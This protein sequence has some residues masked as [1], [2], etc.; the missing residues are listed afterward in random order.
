[1]SNQHA[2]SGPAA[3]VAPEPSLAERARTLAILGRIGTL[4]THSRKF[5]G[6][7]FGSLMPYAADETGRPVLFISSMAMHTQNLQQDSRAS[8]FIAQPDTSGDPLGSARVTLIGT[9]AEAPSEEV[10]ELYLSRYESARQWQS[11]TDFTFYRLEVS[12]VYYV[13][14]FGVMG[15]VSEQ[16]YAAAR[17][18]PLAEVAPGIIQHMNTDHAEALR[19]LAVRFA[20]EVA[21]EAV[22]TS[23]DRLGF[24]LRLRTGDRVHGCR[25][26]FPRE[27]RDPND[28]RVV[29]VEMARQARS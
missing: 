25:V 24:R 7:P 26:A 2:G 20:G 29:L 10:G 23:V 9:V 16:E 3:P 27:V 12:G 15:W 17:P 11:Y 28:A 5:P 18:D 4:S 22:M 13:G 6:F 1:V 21:D 8:L 19:L 14:G